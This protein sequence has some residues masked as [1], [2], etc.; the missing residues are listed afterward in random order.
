MGDIL[1]LGPRGG[2][3]GVRCSHAS[4]CAQVQASQEL[5]SLPQIFLFMSPL[6]LRGT[7]ANQIPAAASDSEV[8]CVDGVLSLAPVTF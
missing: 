1:P 8:K 7:Y 3:Y 6:G 5:A 4:V 2:G